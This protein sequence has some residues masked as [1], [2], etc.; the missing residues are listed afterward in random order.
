MTE[1]I[2]FYTKERIDRRAISIE[3]VRS[4]LSKKQYFTYGIF[5]ALSGEYLFG[6]M[7]PIIDKE[8]GIERALSGI[9]NICLNV[10][11]PLRNEPPFKKY[12]VVRELTQRLEQKIDSVIPELFPGE[13]PKIKLLG[14]KEMQIFLE[15]MKKGFSY[16][17]SVGSWKKYFSGS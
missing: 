17:S 2:D 8:G 15:S 9:A 7:V 12:E 13:I 14:D 6:E 16:R 4:H 3:I 1:I 5:N 10:M 11:F